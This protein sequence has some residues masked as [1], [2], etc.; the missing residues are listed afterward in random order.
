MWRASVPTHSQL[1]GI[2]MNVASSHKIT[3]Q[4]A[5]GASMRLAPEYS[6]PAN[7][8]RR[9]V[10]KAA[11]WTAPVIMVAVATPAVAASGAVVDPR[12]I[13]RSV[14]GYA[15]SG[16]DANSS[17]AGTMQTQTSLQIGIV[18]GAMP[19]TG[20]ITIFYRLWI[21]NSQGTEFGFTN[22]SA[23]V[24]QGHSV[25]LTKNEEQFTGLRGGAYTVHWEVVE[26][27]DAKGSRLEPMFW[28]SR[29]CSKPINVN[30][31]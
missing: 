2:K 6:K 23:V 8:S 20:D 9:N 22:Y 13:E 3:E 17:A 19:T 27:T 28:S 24:P 16:A 31:P 11:A 4:P 25:T 30:V 7:I 12:V 1:F 29:T 15:W 14:Y 5:A 21:E 10:L 26:A 18:N